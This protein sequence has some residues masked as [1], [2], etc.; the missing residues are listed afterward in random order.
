MAYLDYEPKPGPQDPSKYPMTGKNY[1][2][3]GEQQGFVYNPWSDKY[4][5]D[6]AAQKNWQI[7]NGLAEAEVE[8]KTVSPGQQIA[9]QALL[10]AA[11]SIAKALTSGLLGSS[12]AGAAEEGSKSTMGSIFSSLLGGGG[13]SAASNALSPTASELSQLGVSSGSDVIGLTN[14]SS[15]GGIPLFGEGGSFYNTS[16]MYG[17]GGMF[18]SST[19]PMS[20]SNLGI[21]NYL[22]AA[23]GAY[24]VYNATKAQ[25]KTRGITQGAMSGAMAGGSIV[26]GWGHAIGAVVGGLLGATAH[27]TTKARTNRRFDALGTG[28]AAFDQLLSKGKQMSLAGKD[29]WDLGDDKAA[30][31]IADMTKAYGVLKAFGPSWSGYSPEQQQNIVKAMV[32]KDMINSKQGDWLVDDQEGA[33]ALAASVAGAPAGSSIP[34]GLEGQVPAQIVQYQNGQPGIEV[35][36]SLG[37]QQAIAVKD[38]T[39]G[40]GYKPTI[41][42]LGAALRAPYLK[43]NQSGL[44]GG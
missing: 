19:G 29:T 25:N 18:G 12:G 30:A 41:E 16:G 43:P 1:A 39:Q 9:S 32:D 44:L 31:P 36:K 23:G 14:N 40:T 38:Y 11:P 27:E 37:D 5:P 3:Y 17:N 10:A 4:Y 26:P 35:D 34:V 24:G 42:A 20:I 7:Q 33:K 15:S 22:G 21:G 13:G 8:P 6:P 28:D 2:K